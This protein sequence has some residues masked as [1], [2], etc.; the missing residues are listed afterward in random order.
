MRAIPYKLIVSALLIIIVA[1]FFAFRWWQGPLLPSYRISSMPLVQTVVATGRVV[2]VSNTD[3]GSEISGVVLERRV[4][5]GEQ[6]AAGDL[7]LVLSSDDVAAQVRQAEAE[8]AELI[9][10][11]RPQAAVDLANAEVALAQADRNV[12]R[13][14]ELAAISAISDEE[15]EQAIQAQAQARNDLENARLRANALSSGGVEED[16]LRARIAALQAQL[17][18]AQVRSKV[19]GTILT[20][21]VEIGDLVQPGQSLFTIALDGKT[22]IRVP[23]DERN[24]SRLALQQPAVAIADA[25]PDKP[26]PVRISFIAPSIDPQR[27]TVEVRLSVDPVPDFLRQDMTVSVNI[28]TDQRAKALVIPNDALAN[29]KEDSAEV[30]LLRDGQVQRQRVRLGLRGLSASEVLSGLSAGDEILVDATVSLADGKRVRTALQAAPF[31]APDADKITTVSDK[32]QAAE[33]VN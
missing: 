26:F 16:L 13:R 22:E 20:R 18:K 14:R 10:S 19:S 29:V 21:N 2:A 32:S 33:T 30:L 9:S 25:Y 28:E 24:L 8:L 23:L 4:A 3:I 15:M 11:T 17:N 1:G 7:L 6:V 12:E 27:G 31:A 5:E